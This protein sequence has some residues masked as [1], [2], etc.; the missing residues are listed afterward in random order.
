M[1]SFSSLFRG[2]KS[3]N[4]PH[5][6][7]FVS[8]RKDGQI[9]AEPPLLWFQDLQAFLCAGGQG[10]SR[11]SGQKVA[12]LLRIRWASPANSHFSVAKHPVSHEEVALVFDR[13]RHRVFK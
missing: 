8:E 6:W 1:T 5:P 2:N 4:S 9:N 13:Q 10:C 12:H 7:L 3:T 11:D